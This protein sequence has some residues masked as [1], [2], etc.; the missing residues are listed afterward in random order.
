MRLEEVRSLP[1]PG[2]HLCGVAWDGRHL[3]YSD[4]STHIIYQLNP[5][6]GEVRTELSCKDVRTCLDFDGKNLWQIA[7][8][9]KRIR[10]IRPTDGAVLGEVAFDGDADAIC[11]L[12]VERDRYWLGSKTTGIIAEHDGHDHHVRRQWQTTD[13]VH[14][15]ARVHDVL[16]YTSYPAQ[17]MVGWDT[18]QNAEVARFDLPGHPTGMCRGPQDTF[19]YCDYTNRC[20]TQV[21]VKEEAPHVE[22]G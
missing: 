8:K 19:W 4:G 16:W 5:V 15:L 6:T 3:W 9:P 13:S 11:A 12:H 21:A 1:A 14:G 18:S 20:L 22:H 17:Q 2:E 7:G 10:L